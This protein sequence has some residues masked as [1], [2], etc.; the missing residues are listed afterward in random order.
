MSQS[1]HVISQ[2]PFYL[3]NAFDITKLSA[4]LRLPIIEWDTVKRYN[5]EEQ[6]HIGCWATIPNDHWREFHAPKDMHI[7]EQ[8][9]ALMLAT[10]VQYI[11]VIDF[12]IYLIRVLP[13]VLRSARKIQVSGS[14]LSLVCLS[15]SSSK[16]QSTEKRWSRQHWHFLKVEIKHLQNIHLFQPWTEVLLRLTMYVVSRRIDLYDFRKT[17]IIQ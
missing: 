1:H 11:H 8:K 10:T 13:A 17:E 2:E 4:T 3:G 16:E 14:G 5:S 12:Q 9:F 15:C 6:E 7:S